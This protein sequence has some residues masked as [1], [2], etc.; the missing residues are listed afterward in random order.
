MNKCFHFVFKGPQWGY[1]TYFILDDCWFR[2]TNCFST[3]LYNPVASLSSS[4]SSMWLT[5][6][7]WQLVNERN[8]RVSSTSAAKGLVVVQPAVTERGHD[9][10][11]P[12]SVSTTRHSWDTVSRWTALTPALTHVSCPVFQPSS[13]PSRP[14]TTRASTL[15]TPTGPTPR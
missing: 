1:V 5:S 8:Q 15:I 10:G 13:T 3:C 7:W 9:G 2:N 4:F 6:N 14:K 11:I 12:S